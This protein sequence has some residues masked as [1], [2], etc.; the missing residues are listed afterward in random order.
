MLAALGAPK[1]LRGS[2]EAGEQPA[3]GDRQEHTGKFNQRWASMLFFVVSSLLSGTICLETPY[4]KAC[5]TSEPM[6]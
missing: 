5:F 6:C 3:A 4:D 1:Y 2:G